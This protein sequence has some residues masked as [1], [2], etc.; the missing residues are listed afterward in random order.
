MPRTVFFKP[1]KVFN[2]SFW[3]HSKWLSWRKDQINLENQDR[4]I[5]AAAAKVA[6]SK[7][8][9]AQAQAERAGDFRAAVANAAAAKAAT[10]A[11]QAEKKAEAE[12]QA[13]KE[14]NAKG[15]YAY[16][17][18]LM[19]RFKPNL[20]ADESLTTYKSYRV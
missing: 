7:A 17:L 14:A 12:K 16:D 11:A 4:K 20:Y 2:K 15:L 6:A 1:R 18:I 13:E 9:A 5:N 3:K 10:A 8:K 19:K